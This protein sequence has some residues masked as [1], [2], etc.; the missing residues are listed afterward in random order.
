MSTSV[1]IDDFIPVNSNNE[2]ICSRCKNNELWV[3]LIEKAWAKLNGSYYNI[4]EIP[5]EDV[6]RDMIGAP[7]KVLCHDGE[8]LWSE[9]KQ[10]FEKGHILCASAGKTSASKELLEELGFD[11]FYSYHI[12]NLFEDSSYEE[13]DESKFLLI[14]NVRKNSSDDWFDETSLSNPLLSQILESQWKNSKDSLVLMNFTD[15]CHYFSHIVIAQIREKATLSSMPIDVNKDSWV[16]IRFE[17]EVEGEVDLIISQKDKYRMPF[18]DYKYSMVRFIIAKQ[19]KS[20]IEY[21]FGKCGSDKDLWENLQFEKG[22]YLLFVEVDWESHSFPLTISTYGNGVVKF[23]GEEHEKF[24]NFLEEVYKTCAKQSGEKLDYSNEGE[25]ACFKYSGM[26]QEGYGYNYFEN[27]STGAIIKEIVNYTTLEGLKLMEPYRGTSYE[28]NVKPKETKIVLLK[29]TLK[30]YNLS[31]SYS[32]NIIYMPDQL[33]TKV[34]EKG[35]KAIRKDPR[36]NVEVEIYVY[37]LKHGGGICYLYENKTTDKI[38]EE[39]IKFKTKS[40]EI[41]GYSGN[42]VVFTLLPMENKFIELKATGNNWKIQTQISYAIRE[43]AK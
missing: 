31:F 16:L 27:F 25:P 22:V 21:F 34:K 15:F 7:C 35:T 43:A 20:G 26:C 39:T 42:E 32:S 6:M 8:N 18:K 37:S 2:P 40:L 23:L 24:P 10:A 30:N 9:I 1:I 13:S 11:G 4:S 19:L 38:L 12:I 5:F 3:T 41:I 14:R 17:I 36:L 33:L 29:Q 28:V